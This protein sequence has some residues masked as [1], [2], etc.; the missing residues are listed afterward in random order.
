MIK[1]LKKTN[2]LPS[3]AERRAFKWK[4]ECRKKI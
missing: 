1:S 2:R 4:S 3:K